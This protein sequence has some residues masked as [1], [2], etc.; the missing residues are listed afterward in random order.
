MGPPLSAQAGEGEQMSVETRFGTVRYRS[1]GERASSP[2]VL[3]VHGLGSSSQTAQP[4]ADLLQ[5]AGFLVP[6]LLGHGE[7]ACPANAEAFRM[8]SQ[9]EAVVAV[10]EQEPSPGE[11]FLIAHSYVPNH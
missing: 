5:K 8:Q 9:A 7:S 6:D 2:Q 10:L 4:P 1:F 3:F 11:L